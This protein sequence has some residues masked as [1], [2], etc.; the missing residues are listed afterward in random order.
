MILITIFESLKMRNTFFKMK[1]R[2]FLLLLIGMISITSM[3]STPLME[4]KQKATTFVVQTYQDV[5]T[6]QPIDLSSFQYEATITIS[7]N[8]KPTQTKSFEP[9][10][11]LAIIY[12]VGWNSQKRFSQFNI[13]QER[14]KANYITDHTK[15]ISKLGLKYIRQ[16][17]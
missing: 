6:V 11:S 5:V 10:N 16:T 9:E 8:A 4:Q 12:D 2:T 17:C 15:R 13:Y 14:L 1:S 7:Y 3:A